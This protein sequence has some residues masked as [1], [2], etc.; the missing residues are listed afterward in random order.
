MPTMLTLG[1]SQLMLPIETVYAFSMVTVKISILLFFIRIFITRSFRI[2]ARIGMAISVMWGM[3][4]ILEG[5]LLCRPLAFNWDATIKGGVCG[6]RNAA[7]VAAGATNMITDV[8]IMILPLPFVWS[9]QMSSV[10]KVAL[11]LVFLLGIW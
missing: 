1:S 8:G 10:N 4:V 2:A 6:N 9:L 3:S 5:F 11:S 7:F